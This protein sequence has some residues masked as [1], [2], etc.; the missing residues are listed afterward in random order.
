LPG[1]RT[2]ELAWRQPDP[3]GVRFVTPTVDLGAPSVNAE[4]T[5]ELSD[6]RWTLLC[7]GPR[8]G[9]VVLFWSFVFVMLL[10]SLA[11]GRVRWTPLRAHNWFLLAVGLS[12]VPIAAA[13]IVAGWLLLLGWRRER[14]GP[15][16]SRWH[17]NLRQV[18]LFGW[19]LVALIVLVASIRGGL[20]G[21][22][23]MQISGNG[24]AASSLRWFQDRA[25]ATLPRAWVLSVPLWFYRVAMLLWALWLAGSM[26]KWLRWGW[27]S[28][29]AGGVWRKPPPR[30][31]PATTPPPSQAVQSSNSA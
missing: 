30:N 11:L 22:P 26:L 29:S 1:S 15:A 31:P 7:V 16:T 20:L 27:G 9:P 12:Q 17:F 28:F 18:F 21:Q 13:A 23:E 8:L 14:P 24:S 5:I 10:V 25:S 3:I 2:V 19:T 6:D 4:Q